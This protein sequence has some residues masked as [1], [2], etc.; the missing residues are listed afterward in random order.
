MN[1]RQLFNFYNRIGFN[2]LKIYIDNYKVKDTF[3]NTNNNQDIM[4]LC[5]SQTCWLDHGIT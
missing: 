5:L 1:K 3:I 2:S 4:C